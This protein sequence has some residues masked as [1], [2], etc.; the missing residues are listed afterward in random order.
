MS[1]NHDCDCEKEANPHPDN[2]LQ[3]LEAL[4]AEIAKMPSEDLFD[5]P[6]GR[7]RAAFQNVYDIAAGMLGVDVLAKPMPSKTCECSDFPG[8][9]RNEQFERFVGVPLPEERCWNNRTLNPDHEMWCSDLKKWWDSLHPTAREI[10][11]ALADPT[12]QCADFDHIPTH[13][14]AFVASWIDSHKQQIRELAALYG[15][16]P[17]LV[18]G[19]IASEMLYDYN[20]ND[21]YS[22]Q[23][24]IDLR[25]TGAVGY[26]N[27]HH[28]TALRA[29]VYVCKVAGRRCL[30]PED[31]YFHLVNYYDLYSY[32][33]IAK[34]DAGNIEVATL[35]TRWLRDAYL[36]PN[37]EPER[38]HLVQPN[39]RPLTAEDMATIFAAYRAGVGGLSPGIGER[40]YKDLKTFQKALKI[41][42]VGLGCN[43]RLALPVMK[44]MLTQF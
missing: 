32:R 12:T 35:V 20:W 31:S 26:A 41:K 1:A 39:D 23:L 33:E 29:M 17:A 5:L 43:A 7:V 2:A 24:G 27:V 13:T 4:G 25:Q 3:L 6:V 18:A 36:S 38:I 16:N 42:E 15:T 19:I 14:F 11:K 34:T 37:S 28:D 40:F 8:W 21:F 10:E 22:D 30:D 44:Y 9:N